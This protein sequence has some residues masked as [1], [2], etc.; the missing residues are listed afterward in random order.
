MIDVHKAEVDAMLRRAGAHDRPKLEAHLTALR[1][2]E[3]RIARVPVVCDKPD[4]P[5]ALDPA[6]EV[7][8]PTIAELSQPPMLRLAGVRINS[9]TNGPHR[10]QLA[11]AWSRDV[12][13]AQV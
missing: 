9:R 12:E 8:M 5:P 10:A 4:A 6:S 7:D 11:R 1:D 2:L 13:R 3:R